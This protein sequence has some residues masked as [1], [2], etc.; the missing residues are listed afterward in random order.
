MFL[1]NYFKVFLLVFL[2]SFLVSCQNKN[3]VNVLQQITPAKTLLKG[4]YDGVM[5]YRQVRQLGDFGIGTFDKVNG[6]MIALDGVFYQVTSD[7]NVTRVSNSQ[8]TPYAS[9]HFFQ[10]DFTRIYHDV[11]NI[12]ELRKRL[13]PFIS[14]PDRLYAIKI[15][16][17]FA[18]LTLRSPKAQS[19]PYKPLLD[20]IKTQSIF[21]PK[22]ITGTLVG[23]YSPYY[24]N[25]LIM[26]GFHFHFISDDRTVAGHVLNVELI[27]GE[28]TFDELDKLQVHF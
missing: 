12:A 25:G 13:K 1:M 14:K 15:K 8:T 22:A 11:V 19:K 17:D 26:T 10:P 16:G 23:Y 2:S 3:Q 28:A 4:N 21:T 27:N 7:G 24:M 9:V 20:V 5:S 18:S 6:E